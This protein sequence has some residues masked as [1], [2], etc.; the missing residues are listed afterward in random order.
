MRRFTRLPD[1]DPSD[2]ESKA[3]QERFPHLSPER[4]RLLADALNEGQDGFTLPEL[5]QLLEWANRTA[6]DAAI[7]N[8]IFEGEVACRLDGDGVLHVAVRNDR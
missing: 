6:K 5:E 7:L 1:P 8:G 2:G 4:I 3:L